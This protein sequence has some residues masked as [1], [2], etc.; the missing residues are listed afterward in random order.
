[1]QP[2]REASAFLSLLLAAL[3][4]TGVG[5]VSAA[6]AESLP[7]LRASSP[8]FFTADV[9]ISLDSDGR[10]ALSVSMTVPNAE[11]QWIRIDRGY[12]AGAEISVVFEPLKAGRIY[13]DVWERRMV[14]PSFAATNSASSTLTDK[15]T[16]DVPPGRY[17][18]RITLRDVNARQESRA[19]ERLDVPDYSRVP[20]GF[21][22]LDLGTVDSTGA[23]QSV[24]TR[25]FGFNVEHLAARAALFDR[26]PGGW[27][28][29]YVFRY[30]ILNDLGEE[31]VTGTQN[32]ALTRSAEPVVVRPSTTDLFVGGYT[33]EVTLA[34]ERSKWRVERT[35]E[36]EESGPPRGR[37]FEQMLEAL[38]Y[39]AEAREIDHLRGLPAEEQ[40]RG[41]EEFWRKRDPTPETPRNEAMLEFLR[42]V[43]YTQRHFQGFGPG[44]RSDMGRIYIKYGP[45]D[46]IETRASST[47]TWAVELWYY[48]QPY[49]RFVFADKEGFGRYVLVSPALE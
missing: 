42:R 21:A 49:R 27:P 14:V 20:V 5:G 48:N 22:D 2:L 3:V 13:G 23:F 6:R 7:P 45:P 41:W 38:S 17:N 36:V 4:T 39:V 40:P 37:E 19:T 18:V 15:R 10:P 29:N 8:P 25:L 24:P 43:R 34:E 47:E 30:R 33:F 9:A 35:F 1:M 11:L 28:R 31:L 12:A 26:R 32:V 16:V 44:W 46:Q